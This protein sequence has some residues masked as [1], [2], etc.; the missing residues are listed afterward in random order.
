MLSCVVYLLGIILI[1]LFCY[2]GFCLYSVQDAYPYTFDAFRVVA[3][4][5]FA[6]VR[7]EFETV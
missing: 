2:V 5:Y 1:Y 7:V 6:H 4:V 3:G